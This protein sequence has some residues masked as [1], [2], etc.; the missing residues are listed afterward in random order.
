MARS[1]F[2]MRDCKKQLV[3]G[4]RYVIGETKP[5]GFGLWEIGAIFPVATFPGHID[6]WNAAI[7]RFL[8]LGDRP[9]LH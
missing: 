5:S 7:A 3:R 8:S 2:A 9:A 6:G 1:R 4:K